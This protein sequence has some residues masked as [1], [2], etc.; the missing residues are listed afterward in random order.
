MHKLS[1]TEYA[2]ELV[3]FAVGA[4]HV[5]SSSG[6]LY[7]YSESSFAGL[8]E[9]KIDLRMTGDELFQALKQVLGMSCIVW[10]TSEAEQGNPSSRGRPGR[11]N[12]P[13]EFELARNQH[14]KDTKLPYTD[15]H[16][17]GPAVASTVGG[18]VDSTRSLERQGAYARGCGL[19]H[20]HG[21]HVAEAP[22]R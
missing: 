16:V 2:G 13:M 11:A 20:E 8:A 12:K 3:V 9:L 5:R 1:S 7:E 17:Q 15:G 19:V 6:H 4:V 18:V 14:S 21:G 10:R 22:R